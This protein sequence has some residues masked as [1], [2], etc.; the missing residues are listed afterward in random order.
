MVIG[1]WQYVNFFGVV[2]RLPDL[3]FY[4]MFADYQVCYFYRIIKDIW[5]ELP[6]E[7]LKEVWRLPDLEF[8]WHS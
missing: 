8:L 5:R 2:W 3:G 4:G 7:I 1:R 6:K